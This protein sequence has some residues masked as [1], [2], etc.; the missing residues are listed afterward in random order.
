MSSP[1]GQPPDRPDDPVP[2]TGRPSAGTGTAGP[3][4]VPVRIVRLVGALVL[5]SLLA[6]SF[7]PYYRADASYGGYSDTRSTDA[8]DSWV[9]VLGV[10]A[11][12]LG[13]LAVVVALS[14][15]PDGRSRNLTLVGGATATSLALLLVLVSLRYWPDY[16]DWT[17]AVADTG[18]VVSQTRQVGSYAMVL[19][20]VVTVGLSWALVGRSRRTRSANGVPGDGHAPRDGAAPGCEQ[21]RP[22][23]ADG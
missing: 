2:P 20:A 18:V 1:Q 13:S 9:S 16:S 10:V 6:L 21:V 19:L 3:A 17:A 14:R 8:W 12:L 5:L 7:A 11:L 23:S 22:P 15:L 4:A